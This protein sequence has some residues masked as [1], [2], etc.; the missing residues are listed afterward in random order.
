MRVNYRFLVAVF[1]YLMAGCNNQGEQ[2]KPDVPNI[3]YILA[4]DLGYG[5]VSCYNENSRIKTPNID[6]LASQGIQFTDAHTSSAVCTPTR[7]G[8]LTGRYNWRSELKRGVLSGYSKALIGPGRLTV[9]KLLQEN[10]YHTAF[11]GKWHLGWDWQVVNNAD[12]QSGSLRPAGNVEVDFSKEIKNGPADRGFSYSYG[13]SGSLDMPPYVYVK[14]GLATA[15]PVDT[16]V[17][18]DDKGFW[19]KGLTAPDFSHVDVLPHLTGKSVQYIRERAGRNRPFFLYFALPAPHTPILPVTKFLGKSNTN[20]YGDF[21]L[22]VDD[23]VGQIMAAVENNHISGNTI[24]IFTSD[25]GCSPKANFEELKEVGHDPSY[26]FRGHKADIYEGG[27]RVPFI[28]RWPDKVEA[29]RKSDEIICTTDLMAT[30]ANILDF[31]LPDDAAEDSYSF[32]PVITGE[33]YKSPVR[34]AIVHHS[35]AGRFAIR[36]ND[37]KLILWPG[38]GGWSY[39]RDNEIMDDTPGFQLYNLK[40]DP[41]ETNNLFRDNPGKVKEL[42]ELMT[43][44]IE[45]GRS[46]PG[47]EQENEGMDNW[48]QID[49][50]GN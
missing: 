24:V 13:F 34:E 2:D 40:N 28:F 15:I 42:K 26:I 18:V 10:N 45:Q 19:R 8:I 7:Y 41:S 37:W 43:K 49:W 3:I 12:G 32:L 5:D 21:V 29:G 16:T 11:I 17:C 33:N 35:I 6:R 27:H 50:I 31:P 30:I 36:Q 46:T 48:P 23:V 22:Q 39:P 20:F 47:E 38:S 9:G 4:D 44:Y 14:N 1:I 25:N